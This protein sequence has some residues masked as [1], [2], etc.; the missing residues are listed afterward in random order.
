MPI[1]LLPKGEAILDELWAELG[2]EGPN[3]RLRLSYNWAR[4]DRAIEGLGRLCRFVRELDGKH[5]IWANHASLNFISRLAKLNAFVDAA[6]SDHYPVTGVHTPSTDDHLEE[7]GWYTDRMRAAAPGKSC[8][9]VLQGFGWRD[10]GWTGHGYEFGKGWSVNP[11][12]NLGRRPRL[13][14]TRFMA[15]DAIV[16]GANGI[17]YYGSDFIDG[18]A[19]FGGYGKG[20]PLGDREPPELWKDMMTIG[21][22]LRALEPAILGQAPTQEPTSAMEENMGPVDDRGPALMLRKAG[23]DWVL[24]AV[25]ETKWTGAFTVSNLPAELEGATLYL[26]NSDESLA[27]E[28]GG[29]RDGIYGWGVNVYATSRRFQA[30]EEP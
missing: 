22:E 6:G 12:K 20:K 25:N 5:L 27:V 14:E 15:Y 11:D 28:N 30:G 19:H 18:G 16:H 9:M 23:E 29:F 24:I 2:R 10:L 13:R 17:L 4:C 26:L 7:V 21:R 8:W 3:P 1:R